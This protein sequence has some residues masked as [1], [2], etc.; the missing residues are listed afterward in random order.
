VIEAVVFDMDGVIVDSEHLWDEVRLQLTRDW[1]GTWRDDAQQAMMGMSSTEWSR[2]MRDAL[3]IDRSPAEI[4]DEVVARMR[5][6][7]EQ[8]LPLLPGAVAAVRRLHEAFRLAIASSAN[9]PLID[10]VL[11]IAEIATLFDVTVSSEEVP[12]GKPFPD[13]YIETARRL[14]V[15]PAQSVAIEDSSNGLR[16]AHAAGMRVLAL[17]NPHFPPAADA[18]ALAEV[19]LDSLDDL[20]A[21][22]VSGSDVST[23]PPTSSP[24]RRS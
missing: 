16:A 20:T 5:K 18:L 2:Y 24:Q 1:G 9:R 6:R 22:V 10:A 12:R 8:G 13:V 17:P 19:T 15:P 23:G 21:E 11:Q 7:Y 4:N 3:A 14:G